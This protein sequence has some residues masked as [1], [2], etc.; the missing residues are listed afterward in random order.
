MFT[1]VK[2]LRNNIQKLPDKP[3][4]YAWWAR[5]NELQIILNSLDLQYVVVKHSLEELD[6]YYCVYVGIA[7]RESVKSRLNWHINQQNTISS[8]KS[9]FL[10]TLR[11]SLAGIL[12][13]PMTDTVA[14][15]A[16]M[17][18]L[19]VSY[20]GFECP[21][22]SDQAKQEAHD[23]ENAK[24]KSG[25]LYVLNIQGNSSSA[26]CKTLKQLRKVARTKA[27]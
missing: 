17:D 11:Q 26:P 27:L 13:V 2:S 8:V 20:R 24:L 7:A 25:N 22:K 9:G 19:Y 3:G 10:S 14:V 23:W 16:F 15:N 5:E 6:G 12:N 21:V 4:V 1:N 18:E